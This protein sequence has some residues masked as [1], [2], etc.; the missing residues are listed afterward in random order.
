[1]C[2]VSFSI[3]N[4]KELQYADSLLKLYK[5]YI[6]PLL[7]KLGTKLSARTGI[8]NKLFFM[9]GSISDNYPGKS[10]LNTRR[11]MDT[12]VHWSTSVI[13][14]GEFNNV[15]IRHSH[16]SFGQLELVS[17]PYM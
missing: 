17:L 3:G 12:Y 4:L 13:E 15:S 5:S 9:T 6:K 16:G 1:V 14:I 2:N 8:Y 10:I 11:S 7:L